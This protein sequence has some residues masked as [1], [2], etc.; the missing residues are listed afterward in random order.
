MLNE[1]QYAALADRLGMDPSDPWQRFA[2]GTAEAR[3]CSAAARRLEREPVAAAAMPSV[4][5]ALKRVHRGE[6]S[7]QAALGRF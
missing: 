3:A 7:T 5:A 4:P 2:D 1:Q 6:M